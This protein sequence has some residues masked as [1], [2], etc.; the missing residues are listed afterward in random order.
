MA[1]P[2]VFFYGASAGNIG[3]SGF[4]IFLN[5]NHFYSFTM[6]CGSSTNTRAKLLALWA[7]LRVCLLMGLPI[8][9]IYG[10]SLIIISWLNKLSA[11]DVPALMHWSGDIKNILHFAPQVIF[12]H[13]FREHNSLADGLSKQAMNLDMGHGNYSEFLDGLVINKGYYVLF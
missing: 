1:F 10:D 13:I 11:F 3:G 5:E 7:I 2:C 6:G 4:V 12:K 9:L 8:Q